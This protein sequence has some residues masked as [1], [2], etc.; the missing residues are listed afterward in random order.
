MMR[1]NQRFENPRIAPEC[2]E[3]GSAL[4]ESASHEALICS[5][6]S[7]MWLMPHETDPQAC[8]NAGV[9]P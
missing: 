6:C 4:L 1:P 3:C 7:R 2:P 8:L 9:F 5:C